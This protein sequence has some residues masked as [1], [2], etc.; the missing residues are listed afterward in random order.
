[1][2]HSFRL[3]Y[4]SPVILTFTF[5]CVAV[6]V[7]DLLSDQL[8]SKIFAVGGY[9][10]FMSISGYLTLFTYVFA[11]G[12]TVHLL[13][14]MM[15]ILL[16]GPIMEEK[17]GGRNLVIIMF[18]TAIVTAIFN[19]LLF[20]TGIIGASGIVFMFIVLVSF[21]NVERGK[22]PLTFLLVVAL[23]IGKEI[24]NSFNPDNISQFAHIFGGICGGIFGFILNKKP[25]ANSEPIA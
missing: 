1:M 14:N 15:F 13:N 4:N 3:Q 16:L 24:A 6:F 18:V 7:I 17:Y 11:H 20:D 19:L 12:D 21:T 23:Y 9:F 25:D 2:K 10:D 5:I 22:I 8:I